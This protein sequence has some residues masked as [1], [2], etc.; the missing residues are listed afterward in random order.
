MKISY[1]NFLGTDYPLCFSMAASRKLS[2]T[3]GGFDKMQEKLGSGDVA[4]LADVVDKILEI[5][6]EA[7]RIY[8]RMAKLECPEP[9]ACR[10]SDIIDVSDPAAVSA[11]F[12]AMTAGS[13]REVEVVL[14]NAET[15]SGK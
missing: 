3:F 6:M 9:L 12:A 4:V 5:L 8:C 7:G 13:E 1:I 10:P 14:K 2:E 15:T 11:I